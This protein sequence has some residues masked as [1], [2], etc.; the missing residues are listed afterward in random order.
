MTPIRTKWL[1]LVFALILALLPA[2]TPAA[3]VAEDRGAM[4]LSQALKRLDVIASV[5]HTG[6]HPDDENSA[7]LAW[8]ARGQGVRTAYLSATRGE[9]GVNLIGTELFE[10]LG[11]IRTEELM[12][13]RRLDHAQQFFTP[14]YEFGFS[15]SSA[16]TFTKWNHDQILGDYVR[17]IRYFRP[18]IIISRFTGTPKDGHGHHQVSG[19]ITQEAFKAAADPKL[20]PEYGKPWQAK[21][22]YL[23]VANDQNER[24]NPN[25]SNQA[26]PPAAPPVGIPIN[27][28][29]FDADLGRSYGEIAA[30]GRSQHRSQGQGGA[31]ERGPRQT[32]L[33][34]V[35]K[36]VTVADDAPLFTGILYKLADLGQLEPSLTADLNGLEQRVT[37]IRQKINLVRPADSVP[38]L[39][40][41]LKDLQRIKAKAANEQARFLLEKKED[42]F[43]DAV[44]LAAGLTVDVFVSDDTVVPGQ[45]FNLT[46]SVTNGGPYTFPDLHSVTDLPAG[47]TA[48]YD[49][50]T[51]SLNPGQRL[52]Q[53]YKVKVSDTAEF[54]QP[55][56]LRQPRRGERF[57]WPATPP[58][59]IPEDPPLLPTRAE[60]EYQGTT[61]V[62]KKPAEFRRVDHIYGEERTLL[63]V[64]PA[65]SVTVSPQTAI[66]PLKGKREKEFTVTLEN[67][68]P[69]PM[70]AEVTLIT[71]S[72]WN[73]SP[74]TRT[75]NLTRRGEKA[76]LQ[77]TIAVPAVAG[78]FVVQAVAKAGNQELKSGYTTIAYPHIE[79]RYIYSPAQSKVDVLDVA[80][81]V[82]S[83]GYIE[84][85]GDAVPDALK[86]LGIN[87]T[88][89]SPKDVATADLSK[90][91]AIVLGVRAYAVRD[92]LRAY[93]KRLLDYVA[94]GGTLVVQYNRGNEVG[95]NL[96]IG[97]YPLTMLNPNEN[98]ADRV[99]H[100]DAPV[101]ILDPSNA[102][103]NVPNKITEGDF[104]G[105][106]DERGTYFLKN[107]DGKYTPLLEMHDPGEPAREGGLV[108]G[109]YGKGTY[110]Y[111]GLS[112]FRELPAGV[113]GAYRLFAN[114]VSV[115]N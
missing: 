68:N 63:K 102:L 23:N 27:V 77:F 5:L 72:G 36:S 97:P 22:L 19:I 33:Q 110:I 78:D 28:G 18:E 40:A 92:D 25:N 96:Q 12:A 101:K 115:E 54:N 93:N 69:A 50:S 81:T 38:D 43:Q 13:A 61:I 10:S 46:V 49:S 6:A 45:E 51:G 41:A 4:G 60:V 90:F 83:V 104:D 47:W 70:N 89:L 66:V 86:Q 39:A 75:V 14:N 87:V 114:I 67:Q 76:S 108:V 24:N 99:T 56:W 65:L 30:E 17:V 80:T 113:K 62:M 94:G 71:P 32:R 8:L 31:Q 109:K 100:E 20:F 21:K 107:W 7:L 98:N 44:R 85:T 79:T 95:N 3:E 53:K 2:S 84:G 11:V 35:Q 91:P 105:W 52:D 106:I 64:V 88:V 16:D 15:K 29:E 48:T 1:L 74:A 57:V 73:V 9:G 112:F 59:T 55:Y 34:L 58:G 103:L 37:A 26:A 82:E 111:T 42:D